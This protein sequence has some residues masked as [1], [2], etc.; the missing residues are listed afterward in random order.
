[1]AE[2]QSPGGFKRSFGANP[3]VT[4]EGIIAALATEGTGASLEIDRAIQDLCRILVDQDRELRWLMSL[5]TMDIKRAI[6]QSGIYGLQSHN[7]RDAGLI[8][9]ERKL[10]IE[11]RGDMVT[12]RVVSAKI[13]AVMEEFD[14]P[15]VDNQRVVGLLKR[16]WSAK[17]RAAADVL[18]RT[19]SIPN[20]PAGKGPV[21]EFRICNAR[22]CAFLEAKSASN[23]PNHV[24]YRHLPAEGYSIARL[25]YKQWLRRTCAWAIQERILLLQDPF[26]DVPGWNPAE[27]RAWTALLCR[28]SVDA[29]GNETAGKEDK[30]LIIS[31]MLPV[32]RHGDTGMYVPCD[33]DEHGNVIRTIREGLAGIRSAR[34][35]DCLG[36]L[37]SIRK[38]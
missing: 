36:S 38:P 10:V 9:K 8:L 14:A 11:S 20:E 13:A 23:M 4:K 25:N 17:D 12:R 6:N 21:V 15:Q 29:D 2:E 18:A 22:G 35:T 33:M 7:V 28:R 32:G 27:A 19:L 5:L 34:A 16:P 37:D 30:T 3:G 1:M 31:T 26:K 24:R